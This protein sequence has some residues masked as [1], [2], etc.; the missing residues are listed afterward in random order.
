MLIQI[1]L[2]LVDVYLFETV[3]VSQWDWKGLL[4]RCPNEAQRPLYQRTFADLVQQSHTYSLSTFTI[5]TLR[6]LHKFVV[7]KAVFPTVP[8]SNSTRKSVGVKNVKSIEISRS[9]PRWVTEIKLSFWSDQILN[10]K[11]KK[12]PYS[13]QI[14]HR[15]NIRISQV[16]WINRFQ[17]L[18]IQLPEQ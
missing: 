4:P 2:M 1:K 18:P 6:Y 12:A 11:N 13:Q 16:F 17:I 9:L 3:L 10:H 5:V 8:T 15:T 14:L 7:Q